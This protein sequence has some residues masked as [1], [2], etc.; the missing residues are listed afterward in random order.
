MEVKISHT[1][2]LKTVAIRDVAAMHMAVAKLKAA[3]VNCEFVRNQ[4]PRMYYKEQVE[5]CEYVLQL[6]DGKFDV[7]FKLQED[8]T[9]APVF[10]EWGSHVGN[11]VGADVNV[12]PMPQSAE[13]RAQHQIGQFM[14]A[15]TEAATINAAVAQGYSVD[16][17]VT[18]AEGNVHLILSGM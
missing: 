3:G 16:S 8:G 6:N 5:E 4:K 18:D 1:T 10:D 11:Q 17:T 15:Y 9:Y 7:G 12:C 14:Q 13:G 2:T